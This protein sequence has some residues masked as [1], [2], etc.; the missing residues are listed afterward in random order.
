[1]VRFPDA[2]A[3]ARARRASANI[4]NTLQVPAEGETVPQCGLPRQRGFGSLPAHHRSGASRPC[5]RNTATPCRNWAT[6]LFLTDGGIETTLIFHQ[7]LELP[8]FAAFVLLRTPQGRA[9]LAR[10]FAPYVEIAQRDRRGLVLES[11]TWRSN[12]DWGA[13]LGYYAEALDAVNARGDRLHPR[14]S[15]TPRRPR[16]RRW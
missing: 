1:M 12:P 6:K 16:R 9:E 13:K 8:H 5:T 15:A 4:L 14:P 2:G 7:G 3:G 11:A 10:Y